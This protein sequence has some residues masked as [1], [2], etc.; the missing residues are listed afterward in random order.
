MLQLVFEKDFSIDKY[1]FYLQCITDIQWIGFKQYEMSQFALLHG[2]EKLFEVQALDGIKDARSQGFRRGNACL[3]KQG[4]F[5]MEI[6]TWPDAHPRS[7][8]SYPLGT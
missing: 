2:A 5:I 7:S 3:N 8:Q 1:S 4:Q 6:N